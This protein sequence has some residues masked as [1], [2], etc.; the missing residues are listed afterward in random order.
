MVVGGLDVSLAKRGGRTSTGRG[1]GY[2]D[3]LESEE[4]G[5][6]RGGGEKG[7]TSVWQGG[8]QAYSPMVEVIPPHPPKCMYGSKN[9]NNKWQIFK[10]SKKALK[11]IY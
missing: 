2:Y 11:H 4:D 5:S 6:C 10:Q 9:Y 7:K 1:G 8:C 3:S